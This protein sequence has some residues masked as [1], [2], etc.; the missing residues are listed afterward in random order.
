MDEKPMAMLQNESVRAQDDQIG[1]LQDQG[2]SDLHDAVERL[3]GHALFA[4]SS[5]NRPRAQR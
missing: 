1:L 2:E 3:T 4:L 5:Y